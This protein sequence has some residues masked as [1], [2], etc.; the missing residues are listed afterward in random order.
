M[1]K[2]PPKKERNVLNFIQI[3]ENIPKCV[4]ITD[5]FSHIVEDCVGRNR[6]DTGGSC[7]KFTS[8]GQ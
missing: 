6:Q 4:A 1:R 3:T 7:E 2:S 5:Q 8:E